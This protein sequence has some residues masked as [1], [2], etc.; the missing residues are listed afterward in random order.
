[1]HIVSYEEINCFI[2]RD[3]NVTLDLCLIL[4]VFTNETWESNHRKVEGE[5]NFGEL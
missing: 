4:D 3:Q 1:M 5:M 2:L